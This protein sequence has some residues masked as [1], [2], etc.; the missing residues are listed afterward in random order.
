MGTPVDT[1]ILNQLPAWKSLEEAKLQKLAL[2][3]RAIAAKEGSLQELARE[4]PSNA[5]SGM[6][7]GAA[8]ESLGIEQQVTTL[9][10]DLQLLHDQFAQATRID[11]RLLLEPGKASYG[12]LVVARNLGGT[13]DWSQRVFRLVLLKEEAEEQCAQIEHVELGSPLGR[14]LQGITEGEDFRVGLGPNAVLAEVEAILPS[15]PRLP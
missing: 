15:E 6:S 3:R 8:N 7:F 12:S 10:D 1:R 14:A 4:V 13:G 5:M 9:K 11:T 2:L